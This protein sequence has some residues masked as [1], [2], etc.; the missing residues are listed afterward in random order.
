MPYSTQN[1]NYILFADDTSVFCKGPDPST[2]FNFVNSQLCKI[3]QWMKSNKLIL[4]IHKTNYIIFGTKTNI[5]SDLNLFYR[6]EKIAR[7]FHTKFLGVVIDDKLSWNQHV[8]NLCNTLSKNIGILYRL[9]FLPQ[10]VLLMLFHALISSHINY[11]S[12]VWGFTS[13][14]NIERIYK[15]Q[16]RGIRIITHSTYLAHSLPLFKKM[17]VLPI[18]ESLSLDT[19]IFM[20][21]LSNNLLPKIYNVIFTLNCLIHNHNT[22]NAQNIRLPLNRTSITQKSIFFNGPM[23]W[24]NLPLKLKNSKTVKQFK[25]LYKRHLLNSLPD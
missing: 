24:N 12:I 18:N 10:N 22:R 19:A 25:Q 8:N 21:N 3:S 9:Q 6:N 4:N 13:K 23:L 14:R 20:F 1:L 11:C 5:S 7:V 2:L 17:Q 15:L 16:K